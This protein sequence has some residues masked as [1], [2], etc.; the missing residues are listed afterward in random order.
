[1]KSFGQFLKEDN[2]WDPFKAKTFNV[3]LKVLFEGFESS[4]LKFRLLIPHYEVMDDDKIKN[5]ID[6]RMKVFN[7]IV[8]YD[9][10][11][12]E[13]ATGTDRILFMH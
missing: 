7:N 10:I 1:M 5:R 11:K 8:S 12:L 2:K 9:V 13:E 6:E 3:E 4:I